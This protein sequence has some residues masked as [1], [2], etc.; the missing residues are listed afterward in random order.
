MRQDP[1]G[2]E[3]IELG[4]DGSCEEAG[5]PNGERRDKPRARE[6]IPELQRDEGKDTGLCS[7]VH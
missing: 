1:S 7:G 2:D 5:L 6:I 3:S 4:S